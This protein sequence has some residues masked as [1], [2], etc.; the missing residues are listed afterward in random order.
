[1]RV[2]LVSYGTRGD[3]QPFVCLGRALADAGHAV[4][5]TASLDG[6]GMV[7][8]AGLPFRPLALDAQEMLG[9]EEA[10]RMLADGRMRAFFRWLEDAEKP[11]WERNRQVLIELSGDVDVIVCG[12]LMTARCAA[13]AEARG[14]PL[15]PVH[16][17]P[18]APSRS[19]MPTMLPQRSLGPANGIAH[20]LPMWTFYR[21]QRED[22]AQLHDELG[23]PSP[24]WRQ[25][26]H[27]FGPRTPALL[28]YSQALFP[29]PAGWSADLHPAGSLQPWPELRGR[30]GEVGIPGELDEWLEGG[31]APVFFGFGSMPVLDG[32]ATLDMIRTVSAELGVRAIVAA[33]W[34]SLEGAD[35]GDLFVLDAVD[36]QSLLPRCA[37]AVHH[38]GAGTTVASAAAGIPTLV[39]S[40]MADQPFWGA[41]CRALGIGDTLPFTRLDASSLTRRLRT[42]LNGEVRT[43]AAALGRRIASEDGVTAAR[44]YIERLDPVMGEGVGRL[45]SV[46]GTGASRASP[47]EM[48]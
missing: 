32:A 39:C 48:R 33:G 11:F 17:C 7:R 46:G 24:R 20:N 22:L 15:V 45:S 23:L 4:E 27:R 44:T 16:L 2:A 42:C 40:V 30:L 14:I 8:A 6:E 37:A 10:R 47:P 12:V 21:S 36:H 28:A 43:R 5:V 1:M 35:E 25:W 18:T 41:R 38:G 19:Y 29:A 34:S 3:V 9:A 31:P 26:R 13:V